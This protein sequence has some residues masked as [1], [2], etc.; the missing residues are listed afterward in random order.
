MCRGEGGGS[1]FGDTPIVGS[2]ISKFCFYIIKTS[3][4]TFQGLGPRPVGAVS[5]HDL[6]L[7]LQKLGF[8]GW[9]PHYE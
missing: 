7:T 9:V 5:L 1:S 3:V 6:F 2:L 8:R 4:L